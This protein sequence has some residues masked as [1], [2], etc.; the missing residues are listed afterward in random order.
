MNEN[1][2]V[3]DKDKYADASSYNE[4]SDV[5]A[6]A[7]AEPPCD[8]VM[9]ENESVMDK[10]KDVDASSYNEPSDVLLMLKQITLLFLL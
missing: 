10:D 4:P 6:D 9:N 3:L 2:S 5:V 1:E 8:F 7:Q